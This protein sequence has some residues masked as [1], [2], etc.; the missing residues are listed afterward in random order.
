MLAYFILMAGIVAFA[1]SFPHYFG[2]PVRIIAFS[3]LTIFS[4]LRFEVG[5]DWYSY[6]EYYNFI[7]LGGATFGLFD[8]PLF[9]LLSIVAEKTGIGII[10]VNFICA[11]I[12]FLG[13]F[14]LGSKVQYPWLL[15]A[16]AFCYYV[17]ALPMG[18][19][20]QAV[21]V[22]ICYIVVANEKNLSLHWRIGLAFLAIGFH[23]SAILV[24]GLVLASIRIRLWQRGLLGA[25]V[26]GLAVALNITEQGFFALYGER[27]IGEGATDVATGSAMHWCLVGIPGLWYLWQWKSLKQSGLESEMMLIGSLCAVALIAILPISSGAVT[28]L[29]M[30]FSF[31]PMVVVGL[32]GSRLSANIKRKL[33][34]LGIVT[35][36]SSILAV[37][38]VFAENSDAYQPYR[39]YITAARWLQ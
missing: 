31:V 33:F 34:T 22:G 2:W 30:Y 24:L 5:P 20:R 9:S 10:G 7:V 4:G 18:I 12:Y 16:V 8:E 3:V 39:N 21:A 11:A 38:M 1:I 26:I 23:V 6:I 35:T 27:Y 29:A 25:L 37:W 17:P 36:T 13:L 19:I 14:W 28:R 15:L 32:L